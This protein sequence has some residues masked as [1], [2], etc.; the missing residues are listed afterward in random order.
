MKK[1]NPIETC[2]LCDSK[3]VEVQYDLSTTYRYLNKEH[4]LEGQEHTVCP[5]CECTFFAPGQIE[6]NN[7]L[8]FEFEL[9]IVGDTIPPRKIVELR[10]KYGLTQDDAKKL[11]KSTGN[12]FSK[13]E[14]GESAPSSVVSNLLLAALEDQEIMKRMALRAR[15]KIELA[16]TTEQPD[17]W[18]SHID[19]IYDSLLEA[20]RP[21]AVPRQFLERVSNLEVSDYSIASIRL[22]D[23]FTN[24]NSVNTDRVG[25]ML[26]SVSPWLLSYTRN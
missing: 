8:Y 19:D 7:R 15:V 10:Q 24:S 22:S 6:R 23:K 4:H 26:P 25:N 2:P 18:I 16:D 12:S 11:F 17:Y 13:W 5:D 21:N 1:T 9:T 20:M 14:R 3:N